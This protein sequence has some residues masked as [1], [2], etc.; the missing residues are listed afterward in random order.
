MSV[1]KEYSNARATKKTKTISTTSTVSKRTQKKAIN[2]IK[3]SPILIVASLCLIIG[4]A[5]GFFAYKMLSSFSMN[6]FKINGVASAE[7]DYIIVDLQEIKN[8]YLQANPT[9]IMDDV[10][11]SISLEDQSVTCKFFGVD[12]TSSVTTKY[13]YRVDISHDIEETTK[14]DVKTAGVYYV[15]YTSS[16]FAFKNSKLVRTIIVTGVENDG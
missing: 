14:I 9:A 13:Y 11:A 4:L 2:T 16:F 12:L 15:E 7:N 3:K 1:K 10:Y 5:G 6:E 8:N